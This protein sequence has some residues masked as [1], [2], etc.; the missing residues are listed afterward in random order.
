MLD[1]VDRGE[2]RKA[3]RGKWLP[4]TSGVT[5][6]VP[7][8]ARSVTHSGVAEYLVGSQTN[9]IGCLD[10]QRDLLEDN[11]VEGLTLSVLGCRDRPGIVSIKLYEHWYDIHVEYN[12]PSTTTV[13]CKPTTLHAPHGLQCPLQLMF[14]SCKCSHPCP[15]DRASRLSL[16]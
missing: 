4:V 12:I 13:L 3:S 2:L 10:A 8:V 15:H 14:G 16:E 11:K 9:A 5:A 7:S 1:R 6:T